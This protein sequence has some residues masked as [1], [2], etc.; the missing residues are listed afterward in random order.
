[1]EEQ[2]EKQVPKLLP[3]SRQEYTAFM[4]GPRRI[5][6]GPYQ[7]EKKEHI[8]PFIDQRS[9]IVVAMMKAPLTKAGKENDTKKT[10]YLLK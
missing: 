8:Y 2:E 6:P 3:V 1:M 9:G 10:F 5:I 7:E 4:E